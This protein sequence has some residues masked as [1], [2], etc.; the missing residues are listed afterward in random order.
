MTAW[1]V[2]DN[3]ILVKKKK[4]KKSHV[5]YLSSRKMI[6]IEKGKE[7]ILGPFLFI[8]FL[9]G[10]RN[11]YSKINEGRKKGYKQRASDFT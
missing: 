4:K 3:W 5:G 10:A 8:Y 9:I 7:I 6:S 11:G 1:L 2:N